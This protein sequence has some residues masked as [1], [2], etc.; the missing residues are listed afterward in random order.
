MRGMLFPFRLLL[1]DTST[2]AQE[3]HPVLPNS[4][5]A[6][7]LFDDFPRDAMPTQANRP[8]QGLFTLPEAFVVLDFQ[9]KGVEW[10]TL[11][12]F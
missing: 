11:Q 7:H 8:I 4:K 3:L 5:N 1:Q 10:L 9:L 6:L 2:R 12:S